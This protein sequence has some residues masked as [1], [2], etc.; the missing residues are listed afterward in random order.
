MAPYNQGSYM[1]LRNG[2]IIEYPTT[3]SMR[4]TR[5]QQKKQEEEFYKEFETI[6]N[7]SQTA[8]RKN[9]V[10][11]GQGCFQYLSTSPP[12]PRQRRQR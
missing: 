5:T 8:W 7:E 12:P 11:I 4:Q 3:L 2:R 6:F 1:K 9:K 10:S